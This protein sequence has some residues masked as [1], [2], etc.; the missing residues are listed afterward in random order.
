M[1]L[2]QPVASAATMPAKES[3]E[4][5]QKDPPVNSET[6][7]GES[8]TH[9]TTSAQRRTGMR[10]HRGENSRKQVK[11]T[12]ALPITMSTKDTSEQQRSDPTGTSKTSSMI[13]TDRPSTSEHRISDFRKHRHRNTRKPVKQW[14]RKDDAT[15][16]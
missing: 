2:P 14:I 13:S 1:F 10:K 6:P 7:S 4:Q 9:A 3:S 5:Q 15:A 8:S 12:A 16:E 11:Q